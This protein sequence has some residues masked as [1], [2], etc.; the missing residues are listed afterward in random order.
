[1]LPARYQTLVPTHKKGLS[2]SK[3]L[4][5]IYTI[6]SWAAGVQCLSRP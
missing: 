2:L 3:L 5:E 1:V 4:S 6:T